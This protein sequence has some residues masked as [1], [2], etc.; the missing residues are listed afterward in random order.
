MSKQGYFRVLLGLA[1]AGVGLMALGVVVN[2][3]A[4]RLYGNLFVGGGMAL[5][6]AGLGLFWWWDRMQPDTDQPPVQSTGH[7]DNGGPDGRA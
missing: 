3:V 4:S 1:V 6:L 5:A 7:H 2:I